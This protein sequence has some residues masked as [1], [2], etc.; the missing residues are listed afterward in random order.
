[1]KLKLVVFTL[2]STSLISSSLYA[3]EPVNMDEAPNK[4][5]V[6]EGEAQNAENIQDIFDTTIGVDTDGDSLSIRGVGD[7]GRGIAV[8]DDGVSLT[9]VSGAFSTDIDTSELEK[10]TVY[11]GPG[12][13]YSVN[14]TGG[15]LKAKSKSVFKMDNN[16][17]ATIGGYGYRYLKLNAHTYFDMDSLANVTYSSKSADNS[18]KAHSEQ[19][20]DRYTLKYGQ[21][22]SDSSSIEASLK[23]IDSFKEKTDVTDADFQDYLNGDTIQLN[24]GL[25]NF[26]SRDVQTKTVDSK[27]KK[28]YGSNLLKVN[29]SYNTKNLTYY[30]DG[31]VNVNNDNYNLGMDIEYVMEKGAHSL[32]VGSSYKKDEMSDNN[33]YLYGDITTSNAGGGALSIDSV[34]GTA[35]GDV[36][37]VS[38]SSN[39][40]FGVYAKDDYQ[41]NSKVKLE[42]SLRVDSVSF[43]VNST[44]YWKY[45]RVAD[46]YKEIADD[47]QE[48]SQTTTLITPRVALI[49]GLNSETNAYASIAQGERSIND[50]Q[51]LVNIKNDKPTN[52]DPAKSINYEIGLKHG[53][54][55]IVADLSIYQN[56]IS[57]EIIEVKD[58]IKYYEN[59]GEVDKKGLD[60]GLKYTFNEIYYVGAN[61]SYMDY[62]F[63]T[64]V[65][66]TGDYSGNTPHSIPNNKYAL[67]TGFKDPVKKVSGKV[68][69]ITSGSFYT[70]DAN[71]RTYEGYSGVTNVMLGWEP[72]RDHKL[73]ANVNNLFDKRY[74]TD[75]S[76]SSTMDETTYAIGSPR[77]VKLTYTYKF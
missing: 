47:F 41:I 15:V 33:Q 10:L 30:N 24:D 39:D 18:Y 21:I 57:D 43:D 28:Y 52:I 55:N 74:A 5:T 42:S 66:S 48:V 36:L 67:Y 72:K 17:K 22:L 23:Y 35:L 11:K 77:N 59:A 60:V 46:T 20:T 56:V 75:A 58:G 14:G 37:S 53:G 73:M 62:K 16:L 34:D 9:E 19:T 51:L 7:D 45:D 40:L 6:G 69:I 2:V 64:Y 44:Q 54:D 25:W 1:M 38:N 27:Y 31:K 12:S 50:T 29:V 76:Y 49:Y 3:D 4:V 61:Y 13:I 26:N 71:T 70:D 68:E 63:V 65:A 8:T 32:L